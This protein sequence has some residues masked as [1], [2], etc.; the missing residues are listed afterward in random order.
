MNKDKDLLKKYGRK[1]SFCVPEGYFDNFAEQMM[2]QL[3][4]K[5]TV[6][7]P[8][9]TT[10]DRIKPWIYMVAMFCGLMFTI[11][12]VVGENPN[13]N[14]NLSGETISGIPVEEI[15]TIVDQTM[16]DDYTLY[17]YL[18]EADFNLNDHE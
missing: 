7:E 17:Q 11:R 18:T 4:E 5:E 12:M 14:T 10:W 16:M 3:P 1:N 13:A 2:K 6:S 9:I 8:A 15:E